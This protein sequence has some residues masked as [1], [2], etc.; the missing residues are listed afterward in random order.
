LPTETHQQLTQALFTRLINAG[1]LEADAT[2]KRRIPLSAF[3]LIDPARTEVL[4][5]VRELFTN[6]RLLTINTVGEVSTVELS[7][8]ALIYAWN[9]LQ[10]WLHDARDAIR[11][12]QVISQDASAWIEHERSIDRLYQGGQ[13]VE[14]LLWRKTTIPNIDED[15]FLQASVKE[16]HRSS[17]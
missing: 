6:E 17:A 15:A 4:A 12:Q 5:K 10:E 2:T 14:A 9:R 7:H 3:T 16:Q 13:L 1:T 11:L 8:E